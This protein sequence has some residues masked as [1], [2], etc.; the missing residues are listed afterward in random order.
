[1]SGVAEFDNLLMPDGSIITQAQLASMSGAAQNAANRSAVGVVNSQGLTKEQWLATLPPSKGTAVAVAAS[2]PNIYISPPSPAP[3][4]TLLTLQITDLNPGD[5]IAYSSQGTND[6]NPTQIGIAD[7]TGTMTYQATPTAPESLTNYLY[8]NGKYIAQYQYTITPAPAGAVT[9]QTTATNLV[10]AGGAPTI[11]QNADGTATY[12]YA[13]GTVITYGPDGLAIPNY[14]GVSQPAVM[15]NGQIN[16]PA[17]LFGIPIMYV[18]AGIAA[19]F[20][21]K[22]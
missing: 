10:P 18:L 20:F 7:Q 15:A 3:V 17:T 6:P 4:G 21:L 14:Q 9:S 16:A 12:H 1:M 13:N 5:S 19:W 8:R 22:D 2:Q 11:V